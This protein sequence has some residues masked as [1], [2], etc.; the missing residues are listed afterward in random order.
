MHSFVTYVP[1]VSVQTAAV[2]QNALVV[3]DG[4]TV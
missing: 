3:H 2:T 4:I 1:P